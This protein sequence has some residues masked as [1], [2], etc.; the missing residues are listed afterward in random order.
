[1][2]SLNVGVVIPL[3]T[4]YNGHGRVSANTNIFYYNN[5]YPINIPR[6][7]DNGKLGASNGLYW[8][9]VCRVGAPIGIPYY[10]GNGK[11]GK[12]NGYKG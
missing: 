4:Y 5:N 9:G 2:W 8:Q 6:C 12:I 10:N 7:D 1:M 3:A 11:V